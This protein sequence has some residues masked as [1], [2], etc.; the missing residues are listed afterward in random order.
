MLL[1]IRQGLGIIVFSLFTLEM[2]DVSCS[3]ITF[4]YYNNVKMDTFKR[5]FRLQRWWAA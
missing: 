4:S 3:T 2:G 1:M 5:S